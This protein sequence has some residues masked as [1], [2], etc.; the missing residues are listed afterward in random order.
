MNE[1]KLISIGKTMLLILRT[2]FSILILMVI[3]PWMFPNS[4]V[5]KFMLSIQNFNN[6]I[7]AAHKNIDS[8][9]LNLTPLSGLF[10]FIGS[11]ITELPLLLGSLIMIKVAKN[12]KNGQIFT[13]SNAKCYRLLGIIYLLEAL[14]LKPLSEIFFYLCVTIN[15]PVGHRMIGFSFT[16]DN[17]TSIFLAIILIAIGH[18]MVLGQKI[19]EEQSLTV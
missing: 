14:L 10:G 13:L 11:I 9:M 12:Y 15:N 19:N 3:F 1:Q 7:D 6:F 4:G 16:I 17:L 2:L 5:G 8:F 18:V